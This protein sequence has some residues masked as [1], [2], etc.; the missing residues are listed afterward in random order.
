MK[1]RSILIIATAFIVAAAGITSASADIV[2]GTNWADAV[3]DYS[4]NIQNYGGSLMD[5]TTEW[6]LTGPAD[7][8]LNEN[9]YAWDAGDQDTVAGW[10][11]GMP[12]ET[13]TMSWQTGIAD[14]AGDDLTIY[15]YGGPSAAA[16]VFASVDGVAFEQIGTIG[17]GTAGYLRAETF[18]FAGLFSGNIQYVQVTRTASGSQTGMFFDAFA[19]N[20][21]EPSSLLLFAMA[22][23]GLRR[24]PV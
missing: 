21:P 2:N 4:D 22:T 18:D 9:G 12:N 15:L 10:R 5:A 7:C 14:L 23:L 3:L 8:D 24:R 20:V 17:S 6:W 16:D 11:G 1:R 13:V 19:G